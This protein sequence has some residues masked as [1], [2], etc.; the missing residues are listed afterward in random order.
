M[1]SSN[2]DEHPLLATVFMLK[3]S[4]VCMGLPKLDKYSML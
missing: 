1:L 3:R 2:G 4:L